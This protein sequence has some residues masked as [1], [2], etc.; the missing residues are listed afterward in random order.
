MS[1]THNHAPWTIR[2]YR[3]QSRLVDPDWR[4]RWNYRECPRW[5][6]DPVAWQA[7]HDDQPS[8]ARSSSYP[9]GA[10]DRR[11]VQRRYRAMVRA[12]LSH[13]D[14]DSIPVPSATKGWAD[15]AW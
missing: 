10:N 15:W 2:C 1:R 7:W 11:L 4:T 13:E 12:A 8:G 3:A 9:G 6:D 5:H 14:Y